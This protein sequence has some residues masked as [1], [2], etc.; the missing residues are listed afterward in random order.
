MTK[1]RLLPGVIGAMLLAL[2]GFLGRGTADADVNVGVYAPPPVYVAPAPPAVVV[3][4]G[5]YVYLVP[6][7]EVDILFYHGYWYRPYEGRWYRAGNYNGPWVYLPHSRVPGVLMHLPPDY[8]SVP[9]GHRRIP[10]G[11]LKKDWKRWERER[12]WERG[13]RRKA[14][15][16]TRGP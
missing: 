15:R 4:P 11:Q 6:G 5:T 7:I 16:E 3:I 2:T 1:R 14:R 13:A 9:P 10:Y 12:Y 8:R